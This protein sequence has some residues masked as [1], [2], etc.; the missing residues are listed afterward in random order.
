MYCPLCEK[1]VI[2]WVKPNKGHNNLVRCPHCNSSIRHRLTYIFINNNKKINYDN[3]LHLAPE[4]QLHKIFKE[5]S[6]NYISGDLN[7][8]KYSN[9]DAIYMDATEL[10]FK[11]NF[12]DC[13]YASHILEHIIDDRK[14]ISEMYR[15]LK[16]KGILI[17]LVPQ[18]YHL[19]KSEED[20]SI[21]TPKGR[22]EK[23][24]QWDHVRNYGL[25]FSER[26]KESGFY[27]EIFYAFKNQEEY[28]E[29]MIYDEKHLIIKNQDGSIL[30]EKDRNN[31]NLKNGTIIYVCTK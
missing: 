13:I 2:E 5:K 4:K 19:I 24:G 21:N 31:F 17:T 20:Y 11:N 18:R 9:L 25:D 14:A 23:Y 10:P 15:V 22:E 16:D 1:N 7:P 8:E 12:F 29:K 28:I 26:L 3:F 6:K 27:V 30:D